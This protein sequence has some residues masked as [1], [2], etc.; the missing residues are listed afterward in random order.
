MK[1]KLNKGDKKVK[2]KLV[3]WI[4]AILLVLAL[5]IGG[6]F[7]YNNYYKT[8]TTNNTQ[9]NVTP[10][11]VIIQNFNFNP[12]T[13]TISKGDTVTWKNDDSSIHRVTADDN[14]FDLGD[15]TGGSTSTHI[16]NE[17]GTFN[18]HCAVH[19]YMKGAVVVK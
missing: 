8:N 16:F 18:Y 3:I 17:V 6:Y 15:T 12:E 10:G 2:N 19:T 14:S 11:M 4:G 7:I 13:I 1:I 9:T 5:G